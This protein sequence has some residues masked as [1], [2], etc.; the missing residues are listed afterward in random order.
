MV[1]KKRIVMCCNRFWSNCCVLLFESLIDAPSALA[2]LSNWTTRR[3][4][5]QCI[6]EAGQLLL[7]SFLMSNWPQVS[8]T[9]KERYRLKNTLHN[10]QKAA[11]W[12]MKKHIASAED[13]SDEVEVVCWKWDVPQIQQTPHETLSWHAYNHRSTLSGMNEPVKIVPQFN[14]N[15]ILADTT[16]IF[17]E[18]QGV[19]KM[20]NLLIAMKYD[21]DVFERSRFRLCICIMSRPVQNSR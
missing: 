13:A 11:N 18:F 5:K 10:V 1:L 16:S 17:F 14:K 7:C 6:C 4:Q 3:N 8:F 2:R 19:Y 15:S 20:M 21:I 12:Y 9:S